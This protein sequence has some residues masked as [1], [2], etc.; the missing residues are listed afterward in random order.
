[1]GEVR[2]CDSRCH[3]AA[4][5]Q[6]ECWC[7]GLFHGKAGEAARQAFAKEFGRDVPALPFE[8]D[9]QPTLGVETADGSRFHAAMIAAALARPGA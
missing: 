5:P 8:T 3:D 6:C 4:H 7:G 9:E 1:M 2:R